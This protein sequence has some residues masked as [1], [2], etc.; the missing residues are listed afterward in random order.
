MLE[1]KKADRNSGLNICGSTIHGL[2]IGDPSY[3]HEERRRS[4]VIPVRVK[5]TGHQVGWLIKTWDKI[6]IDEMTK[7][8]SRW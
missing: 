2:H 6:P 5:L 4:M 8:L 3:H 7:Q 1:P